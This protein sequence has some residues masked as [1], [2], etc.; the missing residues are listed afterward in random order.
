MESLLN[1]DYRDILSAFDDAKVDYL[2]VGA[3]A[4]AAHGY[5]RATGDIDLWVQPTPDNAERVVHALRH[6]GAP[7]GDIQPADFEEPDLILQIGVSPRRIDI[8]TE[9]TAV[10]FE[11]AWPNRTQIVVGETAIPVIGKQD[12]IRNKEATGRSKDAAD[13]D[14]L[15]SQG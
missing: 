9:I 10:S 13:A 8:M 4:L 15:K 2:L 6:F 11:D 7:L 12:L 5:P 3:Y 14:Q 1:D